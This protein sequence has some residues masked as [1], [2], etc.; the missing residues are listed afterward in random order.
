MSLLRRYSGKKV[1]SC[2]SHIHAVG[3][4]G[5]SLSAHGPACSQRNGFE[6]IAHDNNREINRTANGQSETGATTFGIKAQ[7][8][9]KPEIWVLL[10]TLKR[11]LDGRHSPWTRTLSPFLS[12]S[13]PCTPFALWSWNLN[14]HCLIVDLFDLSIG[15]F[16]FFFCVCVCVCICAVIEGRFVKS[17]D[18]YYRNYGTC[19]RKHG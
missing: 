19:G 13:Y 14:L 10:S 15:R 5:F 1:Q 11:A 4:C 3:A 6:A 9:S 12:F 8:R 16:F 7:G 18:K 2:L 17:K